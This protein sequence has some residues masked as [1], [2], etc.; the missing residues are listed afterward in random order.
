MQYADADARDT[1]GGCGRRARQ[2][3]NNRQPQLELRKGEDA[4][5]QLRLDAPTKCAFVVPLD[6]QR[7]ELD[8]QLVSGGGNRI[9]DANGTSRIE[10]VIAALPVRRAPE[11]DDAQAEEDERDALCWPNAGAY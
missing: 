4:E 5:R 3:A 8:L 11:R 10:V 2:H 1:G 7:R 9:L 6:T